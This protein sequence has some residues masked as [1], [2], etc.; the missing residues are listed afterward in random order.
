MLTRNFNEVDVNTP[1]VAQKYLTK[2]L[3]IDGFKFDLRVYVLVLSCDPLRIY[4]FEDG[5]VRLASDPYV[6]PTNKNLS[7]RT[8]HLT[9]YSVN[10]YSQG[11]EKNT[12]IAATGVGSKRAISWFLAWLE[13]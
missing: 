2:P 8:R 12:D 13:S 7:D 10:K 4:L 3:L 5:L 9:N 1:V 11:Y 6:V